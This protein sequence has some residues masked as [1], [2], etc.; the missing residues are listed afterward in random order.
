LIQAFLNKTMYSK[1]FKHAETNVLERELDDFLKELDAVTGQLTNL[2]MFEHKNEI[3]V[4]AIYSCW[5]KL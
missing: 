4:L 3:I 1:F 5:K 2:Q